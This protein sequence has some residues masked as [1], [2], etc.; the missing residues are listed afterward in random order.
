MLSTYDI[1]LNPRDRRVDTLA[2]YLKQALGFQNGLGCSPS[3]LDDL[4]SGNLALSEELMLS[5]YG[6]GEDS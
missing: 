4:T 3:P 1:V 2:M 5:K 6:D